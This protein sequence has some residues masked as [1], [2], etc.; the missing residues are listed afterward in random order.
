MC[1]SVEL[2]TGNVYMKVCVLYMTMYVCPYGGRK[3]TSGIL[4][5]SGMDG[6][7]DGRPALRPQ[8][9]SGRV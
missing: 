3:E 1:V 7:E 2:G 8:P 9:G 6:G 4:R 5:V